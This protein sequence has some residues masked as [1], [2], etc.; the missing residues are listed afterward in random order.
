MVSGTDSDG[1]TTY[2]DPYY[3]V[4]HEAPIP[5]LF[6]DEAN[7]S[8]GTA[9]DN[10]ALTKLVEIPPGYRVDTTNWTN[11]GGNAY[12]RYLGTFVLRYEGGNLTCR[13]AQSLLTSPD[14]ERG[15]YH[16]SV[17]GLNLIRT[18]NGQLVENVP[19][20]ILLRDDMPTASLEATETG[21][22][23]G[24]MISGNWHAQFGADGA[25][26]DATQ[27]DIT[28]YWLQVMFP[29]LAEPIL[30]AIQPG[31]PILLGVK[32]GPFYGT[33][34]FFGEPDWT[35]TFEAAYDVGGEISFIVGAM[36]KETE[37]VWSDPVTFEID[38][39]GSP[40]VAQ[41][42]VEFNEAYLPDGSTPIQGGES[43]GLTLNENYSPDLSQFTET[44]ENHWVYTT[45]Y[46][47]FVFEDGKLTFT[48][49]ERAE[50]DGSGEA[51]L[52]T[53]SFPI[54][55]KYG[56]STTATLSYKIN[57]DAP[58]IELSKEADSIE[59]G[60]SLN[61]DWD[62]SFGSDGPAHVKCYLVKV[63]FPG[64]RQDIT[65]EAAQGES[66]QLSNNSLPYGPLT[67]S[68][69]GYSFTAREGSSGT[70]NHTFGSRASQ[71]DLRWAN[72]YFDLTT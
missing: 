66:T 29:G 48:L 10:D 51:I 59:P 22:E 42:V 1:D 24:E 17:P 44:S 41:N 39:K 4:A 25:Y 18:S 52:G 30:D 68:K 62:L 32:D 26:T 49:I 69:D 9:H 27:P 67:L 11:I 14:G 31:V 38:P 20:R 61:W 23:G 50:H 3:L 57:D 58:A 35:F 43:F 15:D 46:F 47:K 21:L 6:F 65:L 72:A 71:G 70:L 53:V 2:S 54:L 19:L 16:I 33:L 8:G 7:L 64:Q 45:G 37:A 5:P 12:E 34:T 60:G 36:D 63:R 13:L 55:D 28:G 56:K 40:I